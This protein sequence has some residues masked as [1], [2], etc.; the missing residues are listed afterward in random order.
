MTKTRDVAVITVQGRVDTL[1]A[2]DLEQTLIQWIEAG[3]RQLIL[4]LSGLEYISSAGLRTV[5]VAGKKAKANGGSLCCCALQDMVRRVFDVS[6]F[7][8]ILSVYNSLDEA[9]AAQ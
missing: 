8:L 5:L 1:S 4:D 9:L 6:G 7:S 3:E 2:G